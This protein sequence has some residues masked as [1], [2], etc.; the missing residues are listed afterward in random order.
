MK[1][2][3]ENL[4]GRKPTPQDAEKAL[5]PALPTLSQQPAFE[6]YKRGDVIG[7]T[8]EVQR[9]LGEGGFGVV[10][11][12]RHRESDQLFALKTFRDE[13]LADPVSRESF[14]KE[15]LLWS[16][17]K[18]HPCI[19]AA[20]WV[21][22]FNERLFV[23]MD[24]LPPDSAGRVSLG[25]Y[26]AS[27]A[28]DA[29]LALK[30]GIQFCQ[31]M[32]HAIAQGI[33]CHRDIKPANILITQ[34]GTLKIADF[35]LA[36][37]Q[38]KLTDRE[39]LA[40]ELCHKAGME[41][42]VERSKQ[43]ERLFVTRAKDGGFGFSMINAEGKIMC[44]TPGY[45][46]P[47]IYRGEDADTRSDIYS[48]GLVLWQMAAGS[49][50]PPFLPP[51]HGNMESFMRGIY[52]QQIAGRLPIVSSPFYETVA[53]CLRPR[54]CDR[55]S[56]FAE[57]RGD[58]AKI[59]EKRT[60]RTVQT[61]PAEKQP[62]NYWSNQGGSLCALGNY[63]E[64][65]ACFDKALDMEPQY[66]NAWSNKGVALYYL[67]RNQE[68]LQCFENA[69]NIDSSD[70]M[71]W[72]NAGNVLSALG[73]HE[74]AIRCCDRALALQPRDATTWNNKGNANHALGR[75]GDAI[76]CYEKAITADPRDA[77]G[78]YNKGGTLRALGRHSEA[79]LCY[80]KSVTINPHSAS[81]YYNKAESEYVTK[82][83]K[84]AADSYRKVLEVKSPDTA[85]LIPRV[86]QRL[87]E[88]KS[89]GF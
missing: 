36:A 71:A 8:F 25:D 22:E 75:Y 47:E 58:L 81:A 65:L 19:V 6:P 12:V 51:W 43:R 83:W 32:E 85:S 18:D 5:E 2:L 67:G 41:L 46:A 52:E 68:A 34:E 23:M 37:I 21:Q 40:A 76:A 30:W 14:K 63:E 56:G 20:R 78:W 86:R 11:L 62:A 73:R 10:Y 29:H 70:P 42:I 54:P 4:F 50:Q 33:R 16:N 15:A 88:L 1:S 87:Q 9:K 82:L 17:L 49:R 38:H 48:F 7:G 66:A 26:L 74:D 72:G 39:R 61:P 24:Y 89:K 44:G 13:F 84:E 64:A 60:K 28:L 45:I 55:Y 77:R 79:I 53:R 57:L 3:F 35:G 69:L 59:L 31:G 27:G 80:A